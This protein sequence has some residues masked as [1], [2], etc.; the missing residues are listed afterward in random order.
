MTSTSRSVSIA[1][2]HNTS[3]LSK[4]QKTF[5]SLIGKIGKRRKRLRDWETV[6]PAFQKRYVVNSCLWRKLRLRC[7]SGWCIA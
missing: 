6:T 4:A 1:P 5:N 7:R 3:S 2:D